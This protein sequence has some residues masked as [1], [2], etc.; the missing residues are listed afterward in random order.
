[1]SYAN[2][3]ARLSQASTSSVQSSP[4]GQ[5]LLA[6]RDIIV[7]NTSAER[8]GLSI[9]I[10]VGARRVLVAKPHAEPDV[11]DLMALEPGNDAVRC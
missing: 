4:S 3:D 9:A 1:M 6:E 8:V 7:G 5:G 10:K 11:V 2:K